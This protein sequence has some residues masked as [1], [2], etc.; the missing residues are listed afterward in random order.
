MDDAQIAKRIDELV[1]EEHRLERTHV[2]SGLSDEEQARL[3]AVEIQLD[4]AWDL[5]RRRRARRHAGLDPDAAIVE[6]PAVVE[7]YQQ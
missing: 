2:G 5:L 1:D 4:Q 7:G 3:R 6:P